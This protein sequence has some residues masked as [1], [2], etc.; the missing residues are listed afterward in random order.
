[1]KTR[2]IYRHV[3]EWYGE[4]TDFVRADL[5]RFL[6]RRGL[7]RYREE[8]ESAS[9]GRLLSLWNRLPYVRDAE[10]LFSPDWSLGVEPLSM[11]EL[12]RAAGS[13]RPF[14]CGL[15]LELTYM[16]GMP[17]RATVLK[18]IPWLG[19]LS[20]GETFI[21]K[22]LSRGWLLFRCSSSER[23][24][25]LHRQVNASLVRCQPLGSAA[26]SEAR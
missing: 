10:E 2:V 18:A 16:T 17:K 22:L 7:E 23:A 24:Q 8:I 14:P 1:M 26:R 9:M 6:N 4:T 5:L 13:E 15:F 19:L 3:P 21:T 11:S 12:L 20:N 25:Q